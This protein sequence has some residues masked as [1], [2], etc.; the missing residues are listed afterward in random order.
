M[1]L[2]VLILPIDGTEHILTFREVDAIIGK[3]KPR[4][5]IPAHYL[6]HGAESVL[7]GLKTAEAWVGTRHNVLRVTAASWTWRP[8]T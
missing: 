5:V 6:V 3:Y 4:A 7:S 2:D 8:V 1:N